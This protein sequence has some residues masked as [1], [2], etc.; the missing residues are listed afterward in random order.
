MTI[1]TTHKKV[2]PIVIVICLI[3]VGATVITKHFCLASSDKKEIMPMGERHSLVLMEEA[4]LRDLAS[5]I[6]RG[7]LYAKQAGLKAET[8]EK[9][10]GTLN[11]ILKEAAEL[12]STKKPLLEQD[13]ET[14][15]EKLRKGQEIAENGLKSISDG[16]RKKFPWF[17]PYEFEGKTDIKA[18]EHALGTGVIHRYF[19][20]TSVPK[21]AEPKMIE[22]FSSIKPFN[23]DFIEYGYEPKKINLQEGKYNWKKLDKGIRFLE[24]YGYPTDIQVNFGTMK[25][26]PLM[27]KSSWIP[28]KYT[29]SEIKEMLFRNDRGEVLWKSGFHSVLN[30]WHPVI[31]KYEKDWMEAL[32]KYCQNRNIAIYELF[33]EMGLTSN[34]RPAGYSKYA[35][36]SFHSYLKKKYGDIESLNKGWGT[37]FPDFDVITPPSG[38]SYQ[39]G[40]IP[41]GLIYEFERFR[42]ESLVTYMGDMIAELR[43]ADPNPRH[44]ISSQFTGWFND[45][46][47]PKMSARDFLMLA[48]LD[49]NLYGVHTAGDGKFPAINLLYHYSINRYAKKIY[50]NDEFWWD[51]RESEDQNIDDEA[52]LRAV[53]ERNTWRHIA[54]GIKG[55]N[56]YPGLYPPESGN[57]FLNHGLLT[58]TRLMRYAT[59][60]FP[61]VIN[62]ANKY[63]DTFFDGH[64]MNQKVAIL[65]PS[66][67]LDIT[68]S[69]F[70]ANENAIKLSDWM[71]SEH[72]I[73]FYIPEECIIDGRQNIN[74]F[75]VLISPYAPFVP[76][77][78]NEKIKKWVE[79]GGT[80]ISVGPFGN[81]D[82]YGK[83]QDTF[84]K[85]TSEKRGGG[86]VSIQKYGKG[87]LITTEKKITYTDYVKQIKPELESLKMVTCNIK[88]EILELPMKK[89]KSTGERNF[90]ARNDLDLIPWEDKQGN[91]YLFVINLNPLKKLEPKI[92]IRGEFKKVI[93]LTI[94]SGLPV[95]AVNQSG[96]TEFATALEPGQGI[97]YKMN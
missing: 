19:Y 8:A 5:Q 17:K 51:F 9:A 73:P 15:N 37:S 16:F 2:L 50:W 77:G 4:R 32:G 72:I 33:N 80:F 29:G 63:A 10:Q 40:N 54:Y 67:T 70:L 69:E 30:I 59:A 65:Q 28:G 43:K 23:F 88:P 48:S 47:T 52:I 1:L 87:K 11:P 86:N 26:W 7:V 55:F 12:L 66:T 27:E 13:Y 44:S 96:F 78:L 95:P 82:R 76:E 38:D 45:S 79:D 93:D 71:L 35:Q 89:D 68:A 42:K 61:L 25:A 60:A 21:K 91:K 53:A 6:E 90:Y 18:K 20:G 36:I 75:R 58:K 14:T 94:D 22:I 39:K 92:K 56:I 46:N 62:K 84:V 41:I 83:K 57:L 85:I 64:L 49:W 31:L 34:K 3:L 74:E 97:I 24:K 81:F